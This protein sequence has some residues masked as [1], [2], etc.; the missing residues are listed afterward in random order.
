MFNKSFPQTT[1]P[2]LTANPLEQKQKLMNRMRSGASWFYWIAALSVINTI[3]IEFGSSINFI[4]GLGITQIIDALVFQWGFDLAPDAFTV[5][6]VFGL[7]ITLLIVLIFVLFGIYANKRQRWAFIAGMIVYAI[8]ALAVLF[9]WEQPDFLAFAFHLFVIWGLIRGLGAISQLEQLDD[10]LR[11]AGL[12]P[13]EPPPS[14]I[15]PA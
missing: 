3:L 10:A 5:L 6:R 8:D 14:V 11:Q 7:A 13:P 15:Q 12:L 9:V 2:G 1:S 4:F